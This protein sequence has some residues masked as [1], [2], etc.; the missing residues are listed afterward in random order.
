MLNLR[1]LAAASMSVLASLAVSSAVPS[2]PAALI[3]DLRTA[4]DYTASFVPQQITAIG[5][6]AYFTGDQGEGLWKTDGTVAGT[7]LV[8]NVRMVNNLRKVGSTLFFD[9]DDGVHGN[10][11]WA[12]DG[13]T[14]GTAMVIDFLPGIDGTNIIIQAD[15]NGA[16]WFAASGGIWKTDGSA[17][18][19]VMVKDLSAL[20]DVNIAVSLGPFLVSGS[21]LYFSARDAQAVVHLYR[22]DGTEGGTFQ[23]SGAAVDG[24]IPAYAAGNLLFFSGRENNVPGLYV[25]DGTVGGTSRVSTSVRPNTF[26]RGCD[27]YDA[28]SGTLYFSGVSDSLGT[29][30]W[31]SDGT[32]AGTVLIKD[33]NAA[34]SHYYFYAPEECRYIGNLLYFRVADTAYGGELWVSDGTTGGTVLVKDINTTYPYYASPS[35][36]AELGGQL[37]FTAYDGS[38]YGLWRSDGTANG[39]VMIAPLAD[40]SYLVTL[41]SKLLFRSSDAV[42]GDELWVSD[43]T[44]GGTALLTDLAH[45]A[46]SAPGTP[47]WL[48]G[49]A[50]FAAEDGVSGRELW[51]TDGTE[52][53]TSLVKD[54]NTGAGASAPAS[55]TVIGAAVYFSADDGVS[56]RELWKSDGTPAGTVRVRDILVGATGSDPRDLTVVGSTLFFSA[57]DGV[58]GPELWKSDGT[59]GGTVLVKDLVAG[60]TGGLA[61]NSLHG[62]WA[63][64]PL[65]LLYVEGQ[66]LLRSD[67]TAGGTVLLDLYANGP[68]GVV[69]NG[70]F[71]YNG[72]DNNAGNELIKTDGNTRTLVKDIYPC[73]YSCSSLPGNFVAA[74]STVYF[75]A[76]SDPAV[77]H[78]LWKTDGTAAGTV[79]VKDI[80]PGPDTSYV[81]SIV[82]AGSRVYFTAREGASSYYALWT[83][84]GTAAGTALLKNIPVSGIVALPGSGRVLFSAFTPESGQELWRSDGTVAGTVLA[85]DIHPGV[86]SSS[87]AGFTRAGPLLLFAAD[88]GATGVEPYRYDT[89]VATVVGPLG[90]VTVTPDAGSV[91]NLVTVAAPA[92]APATHTYPYGF[93]AFDVTGLAIG[94]TVH[95]T[96]DLPPGTAPT[97]YMKCTASACAPFSGAAISGQAITLTLVDGGAGDADG[98]ANGTISDPGAPAI[99]A[100]VSGGGGGGAGDVAGGGGGGSPGLLLLAGLLAA[101]GSRRVRRPAAMGAAGV[102]PTV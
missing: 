33:F 101:A 96:L 85:Q 95:V 71:F 67:G 49:Y 55:L 23:V 5:G 47:A 3:K 77:G 76:Y 15:Y 46:G 37:H 102:A 41:G 73:G 54:I 90:L 11:L 24:A 82:P 19:T 40:L 8:A 59:E 31:K 16:G 38:A 68:A 86:G 20:G 14:A 25:T 87:P 84:D 62:L 100:T 88:D 89:G 57:D 12:S 4:V 83:S 69:A 32:D 22:T 70:H 9:A 64:D 51:R 30:L 1:I 81:A 75:T 48:D 18:G 79:L 43:G 7:A 92:M 66:G 13:T 39:T 10:E 17:A 42:H 98:L 36:F 72:Y 74:G 6:S 26:V 21:L 52:A 56:G 63:L 35:G 50:Y 94:A 29:G 44:T 93:Y 53:G 58:N 34:S 27:R 99:A 80:A 97:S 91:Q 60:A 78:E 28:G 45:Q 61:S 65:L 2:P